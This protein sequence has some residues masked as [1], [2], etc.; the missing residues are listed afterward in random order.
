M[1][2][3]TTPY[4]G[5]FLSRKTLDR[6]FALAEENQR[7]SRIERAF[8]LKM[9]HIYQGRYTPSQLAGMVPTAHRS[10]SVTTLRVL[11][12]ASRPATEEGRLF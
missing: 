9:A 11:L 4:L 10:V 7:L 6:V 2:K 8:V 1:A 12:M 3:A 5:E